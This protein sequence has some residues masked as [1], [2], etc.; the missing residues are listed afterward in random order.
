MIMFWISI[1]IL[2]ISGY[3]FFPRLHQ[4]CGSAIGRHIR[5]ETH[6]RRELIIARVNAE[7]KQYQERGRAQATVDEEWEKVDGSRSHSQSDVQPDLSVGKSWDGVIGFFH[8]FW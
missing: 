8:P 1:S 5:Q 4:I 7:K 2:L 3:T 6:Q